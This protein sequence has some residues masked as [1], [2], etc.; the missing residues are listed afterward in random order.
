MNAACR[1]IRPLLSDYMDNELTPTEL[2]AVQAHVAGCQECAAILAEYRQLRTLVRAMPQPVPPV[3]LR[4]SVFAK[5]TPAYRHRAFLFDLGQRGLAYGAMVVALV[6]LLFTAS[7][8]VRSSNS[9]GSLFGGPDKTPPSITRWDPDPN[10]FDWG[11]NQSIRITFSEPMDEKSVIAA[12]RLTGEPAL[13][14]AEHARLLKTARWEGNTLLIGG[15]E[16]FHA[17]TDYSISFDLT[18]ARDRAGN[19]LQTPRPT[20]YQFRTVDTIAFAVTPT[21]MQQPT[22]TVAPTRALT[23]V[24]EVTPPALSSTAP[25]SNPIPTPQGSTSPNMVGPSVPLPTATAQ[26]PTNTPA[27][28]AVVPQQPVQP[29]TP[30]TQAPAAPTATP[31]AAPPTA[32]PAPPVP[33]ATAS[34]AA[35]TIGPTIA[36]TVPPTVAPTVAPTPTTPPPTATPVPPT[37]TAAPPTPTAKPTLPFPVVGG[38]GQLYERNG[39]VRDRVGLPGGSEARVVGAYQVF[40]KGLMIWR[41]DSRTIYVLFNDQSTWYAFADSWT[42]GMDAGGGVGP[43]A[44]QFKPKRGFGKVWREQPDVQKR[45]GYAL[46]A[47]ELATSLVVQPFEHGTMLWSNATGKALIYVLYQNNLYE[48]YEDPNK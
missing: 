20:D 21:A 9:T 28:N 47:D 44:G 39:D 18:I 23:I 29:N 42:E 31:T 24:T 38:F 40:E 34:A 25:A 27:T 4:Q 16:S 45:L 17:N 48:Q 19:Q 10:T 35:P 32:T 5:A 13:S 30:P 15:L 22:P 1:D 33:T 37:A 6:A 36:P 41:G 8:A 26:P 3:T 14:E 12:L 7:L 46:S 11:L 43:A 2:R